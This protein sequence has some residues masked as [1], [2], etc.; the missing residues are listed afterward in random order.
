MDV[1]EYQDTNKRPVLD[2]ICPS[3]SL[4]PS[5]NT[6]KMAETKNPNVKKDHT[7]NKTTKKPKFQSRSNSFLKITKTSNKYLFP[8]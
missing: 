7:K 8:E 2:L 5:S 3:S 6:P 1:Q 4:S